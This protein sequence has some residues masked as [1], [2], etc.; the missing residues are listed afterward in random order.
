MVKRAKQ[1]D[2]KVVLREPFEPKTA[3]VE[4]RE[5]TIKQNEKTRR[6]DLRV[7][8]ILIFSDVHHSSCDWVA[9]SHGVNW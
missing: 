4:G 1:V 6:F 7:D 5:W 3:M 2:E 8:G 9:K